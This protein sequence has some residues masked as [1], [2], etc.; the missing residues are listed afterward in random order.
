MWDFAVFNMAFLFQIAEH[1]NIL[2]FIVLDKNRE[3]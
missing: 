3:A 1:G 2:N